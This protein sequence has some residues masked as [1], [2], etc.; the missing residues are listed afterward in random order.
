MPLVCSLETWDFFALDSLYSVDTPSNHPV[1]SSPNDVPTY[2][3][4]RDSQNNNDETWLVHAVCDCQKHTGSLHLAIKYCPDT[5]TSQSDIPTTED[6]QNY[7]H[8]ANQTCSL[9]HL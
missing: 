2:A 1:P 6:M 3:R 5:N 8:T 9:E 7:E 4:T